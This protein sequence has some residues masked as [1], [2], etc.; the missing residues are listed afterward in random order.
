MR[1]KVGGA[2]LVAVMAGLALPGLV[3]AQERK[4]VSTTKGELMGEERF[5]RV[6]DTLSGVHRHPRTALANRAGLPLP[7]SQRAAFDSVRA[8]RLL[9]F[10]VLPPVSLA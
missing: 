9:S 4:I 8:R 6:G 3:A 5:A 1:N 7:A 10:G 2:I